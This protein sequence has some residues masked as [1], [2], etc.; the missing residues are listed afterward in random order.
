MRRAEFLKL[1]KEALLKPLVAHLEANSPAY[2][3]ATK[4]LHRKFPLE[5]RVEAS[6]EVILEDFLKLIGKTTEAEQMKE[7]GV[8]KKAAD[9]IDTQLNRFF[10]LLGRFK[11]IVETIWNAFSLETLGDILK[12][13]RQVWTDFTTLLK[14][15]LD[16]ALEVALKILEL[17]KTAL[18]SALA[19]HANSVPGFHLITVILRKNPFTD[20]AVPRTTENIIRGFMS[21]APGGEAKF[22]ELKESGVVPR[23]AGKIDALVDRLGISWSMIVDTFT[24]VWKSLSINDLVHPIAAFRRIVDQFGAP[25]AKIFTFIWEVVKILVE[26]VLGMMGLPGNI[27]GVI[28]SNVMAAFEKIKK[29][30]VK[31]FINLLR[32]V[33]S[34][35]EKFFG[36]FLTHLMNGLQTW[37][38]GQLG[39]AGITPPPDITFKSVLGLAMQVLG[40]T[41]DN[42]LARLAL[43]IGQDKV[44]KIKRV[45]NALT[46]IWKFVSDVIE[47]GP[48]A[49]WEYVQEKL[50]NLWDIV[51]NGIKEF[52]MTRIIGAVV[53]KLLSFLDPTGIMPVINSFIAFFRAVQTF[54]EKLAEILQI[55]ASFTQGILEIANGSIGSAAA[56]LERALA[57]GLPIAIAFLANQVGLGKIGDKIKEMIE[58][59]REKINE[60]IDWLIDKALAGGKAILEAIFGKGKDQ[61]GQPQAGTI[62]SLGAPMKGKSHTLTI[63]IG[64]GKGVYMASVRGK[65]SDKAQHA[66]DK[67]NGTN[68]AP[69]DLGDR[70]TALGGIKSKALAV[71]SLLTKY[72][73]K[74]IT[75]PEKTDME[76]KGK[77]IV[78]AIN[79]YADKFGEDDLQG[80]IGEYP[81]PEVGTYGAI[82]GKQGPNIDGTTRE[83]HHAPA[84][85]AAETLAAAL[86]EAAIALETD[87][88]NS[89]DPQTVHDDAL[90]SLTGVPNLGN[91][92]E[93]SAFGQ[94]INALATAMRGVSWTQE[95]R[96]VAS[97]IS[98][99]GPNGLPAILI[100]HATHT[101]DAGG[102]R[103]HGSEI[104]AEVEAKLVSA[105]VN[106]KNAVRTKGGSLAVKAQGGH[107]S[108]F[109][110]AVT[111]N[112]VDWAGT[113]FKTKL[114][115]ALKQVLQGVYGS[116]VAQQLGAVEA[117]VSASKVDGKPADKSAALAQLKALVTQIWKDQMLK[118]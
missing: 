112:V 21:L 99:I 104:K 89:M 45:L 111:N 23:A 61:A 19:S 47:R 72:D 80:L 27:L 102:K 79:A 63:D 75:D 29:D 83:A 69:A 95:M 51:V 73:N 4:V 59:A 118:I 81:A 93:D 92:D 13:F 88:E 33:K 15:F 38:F 7:K 66:I 62:V 115:L 108:A 34:G 3:L 40:V 54:V 44:D 18:L 90:A 68:P 52:I 10:S 17:V 37:L 91:P 109:L 96:D 30:P 53:S 86:L 24:G 70:V 100:H 117:A 20:E 32:A 50:N 56:F 113:D 35:F 26:L 76:N 16:F 8:L 110:N 114:K 14:D 64:S 85:E 9:W 46:G 31:F 84:A 101:M 82:K 116:L 1:V 41:V 22:Q 43:K 55:I 6:T 71:E 36:N 57:G 60:G 105:N 5:D 77:A 97:R 25:I 12:V 106:P 42:I 2:Q 49:I 11:S 39:E 74:T 98:S 65:L 58:I 103:V 48:I 107:Y 78:T 94:G 87:W 67:L 28:V